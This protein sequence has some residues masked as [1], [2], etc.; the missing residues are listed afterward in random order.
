MRV[1]IVALQHESNTF[2]SAP[3]N[4]EDFERGAA[5][6]RRGD[7]L[8]LRPRLSRSRRVLRGTRRGWPGGRA[9]LTGL[10]CSGR[11][12]DGRRLDRLLGAMLEALKHAGD[13]DGVLVRR[14]A[15]QWRRTLPIWMARGC[16]NCG[17]VGPVLP[18]IGTLD[19]HA[20]LTE[21]MVRATDA[22]IGY[23]TN[24][25]LDQRE[26]GHDAARLMA[27]VLRGEVRPTQA[28]VHPP[29]AI[30]IERQHTASLPCRDCFE[31][32]RRHAGRQASAVEQPAA[33][34]SIRRRA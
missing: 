22:L 13:L 12:G 9:N 16:A 6:D 11:S 3:T 1:G 5:L 30:N 26:R 7:P 25:H 14:T 32:L 10:G 27:R 19:L 8:G 23:R 2:L 33:G 21:T 20:N 28:A 29:L 34:F 4:W 15:R 18:I 24:P 31:A 17:R